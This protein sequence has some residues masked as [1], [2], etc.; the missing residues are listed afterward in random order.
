MNAPGLRIKLLG[1]ASL[2]ASLAFMLGGHKA[3]EASDQIYTF[4]FE[5]TW[6]ISCGFGPYSLCGLSGWHYGTDYVLGAPLEGG[7]PI[8]AAAR[9]TALPC[10][11]DPYAGYSVV[12]DHYSGRV[13]R[14]LHFDNYALPSNGQIVARGQTI[15][16][17]GSR[18]IG[19][20]GPHLHFEA[21]EGASRNCSSINGTAVDP[22]GG[23]YSPGTYSWK[24][25]PPSTARDLDFSG[26][27]YPDV[28]A[29]ETSTGTICLV[30]GNGI[31][32]WN[33]N[34]DPGC[35]DGLPIGFG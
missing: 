17:E 18:G 33:G 21:R 25:N 16:Y 24:T 30:R 15:G 34:G 29:K 3:A 19:V 10:A 23:S 12:V 31:G 13:T 14:Y 20:T 9:G 32:G 6:T 1:F 22:Y 4:P 27:G 7:H 8:H 28:L 5:G 11:L 35:G 2:L 26:D